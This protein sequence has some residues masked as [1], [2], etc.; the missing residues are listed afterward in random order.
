MNLAQYIDHTNL[1]P[2]A[3]KKDINKLIKEAEEFQF[4]TICI[5]SSW[6]KY[7]H[8][9]L[10]SS[11]IGITAVIGF[12][13]GAMSTQ[14]KVY[15]AK[16]AIS[17]GAS[18]IDM[19]IQIGK[20]KDGEHEYVLND[21]NKV[22]EEIGNNILKVII[23]TALLS[24]KEAEEATLIVKKSKADFVKT[25]TGFSFRGASLDDI[26]MMKKIMGNDKG[27]KA[28]GGIK[29]LADLKNMIA[30]GATRIGTSSGVSLLKEGEAKGGY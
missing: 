28:A 14:A 10:G 2:E 6:V 20:L 24:P 27:I 17:H 15:E 29:S 30:A 16:L 1:R 5:N 8:Q 4:K 9:Q 18:E 26:K 13:L 11:A 21:I 7:A 23:E 3:R 25:S 12:P 19:V 22:K